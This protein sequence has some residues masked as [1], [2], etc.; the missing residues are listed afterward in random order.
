MSLR[1]YGFLTWD[2]DEALKKINAIEIIRTDN[3]IVTKYF[4]T[5]KKVCNVSNKYE[6]FDIKEFL[7]AK[8]E[9]I[10]QNFDISHYKLKIK[11]G[12][13]ELILLSDDVTI[14]SSTY[15]KS[16]YILN[17]SDKSRRLSMY[18]GLYRSDNNSYMVGSIKNMSLHK[19]HYKGVTE[20]AEE[21]SL[22]ID[23]ETFDEQI[24]S[25]QSLV[26]ESVMLSKVRDILIDEDSNI[27]HK[28]FD[29]FK[30]SLRYSNS[31]K[32][33]GLSDTQVKT[34]STPSERLEIDYKNDFSIDAYQVFNCYIQLFYNQDS[35]VVKKETDKIL[36]ITT[37]FIRDSKIEEILNFLD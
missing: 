32:V 13:Q 19:K 12:I 35:H 37:C 5:V 2:K 27:N 30:N 26:G 31:D 8:I 33:K 10:E 15:Y 23:G 6:V 14:N 9:Q 20:K 29:A 34:L 18:M 11:G 21:A 3:Q 7:K 28:K 17:S 25:I 24:K 36:K 22:V 16:F 1:K 4:G